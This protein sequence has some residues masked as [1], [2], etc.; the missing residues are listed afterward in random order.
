LDISIDASRCIGAGQCA[1]FAEGVFDQDENGVAYLQSTQ[2]SAERFDDVRLAAQLC[3]VSAI[4][5]IEEEK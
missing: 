4:T 1:A 3:P 5:I 2:I